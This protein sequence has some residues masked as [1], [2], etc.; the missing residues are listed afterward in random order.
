VIYG[1]IALIAAV[2]GMVAAR[3][4]L[5]LGDRVEELERQVDAEGAAQRALARA[6]SDLV[7]ITDPDGRLRYANAAWLG[8]LGYH[9]E[10]LV[11]RTVF[12]LLAQPFPEVFK[13]AATRAKMGE[14]VRGLTL[15]LTAH[16]GDV[17]QV[18]A[19]VSKLPP[20]PGES[21]PRLLTVMRDVTKVRKVD[22]MKDEFMA[23][24]SHELKTPLTSIRGA[25]GLM[26]TGRHGEMSDT[27]REMIEIAHRNTQRMN[28]LISNLLDMER[29]TTGKI[30]YHR[31]PLLVMPLVAE[32]IEDCRPI[33]ERHNVEL[34]VTESLPSARVSADDA[35]LRQVIKNLIVNARKF[36]EAGSTVKIAVSQRAGYVRVA[37]SDAGQG[38]PAEFADQVFEK[39][40]QADSGITRSGSGVGLGLAIAK[41]II[42]SHGG[43]ID[44][45]SSPGKGTTFWFELEEWRGSGAYQAAS[46]T[47]VDLE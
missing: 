3:V 21:G 46:V 26:L 12:D 15:A 23:T 29:M 31:Q 39:F 4:M 8:R 42:E 17:F 45:D 5:R 20:A 1:I 7:Q 13:A 32:A 19:T 6:V 47:S 33:A 28:D 16:A 37:V 11:D 41:S 35:R 14:P 25:L 34:L 9:E 2:A 24:L 36:S 10:D 22:A 18:E 30:S 44:F 38:I 27:L 40:T 43:R